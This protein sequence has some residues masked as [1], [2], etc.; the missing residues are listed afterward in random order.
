MDKRYKPLSLHD[1]ILLRERAIAEVLAHPE[2]SLAE[3][4]RHLRSGLR[5]TSAELAK[6]A[7]VGHR[8]LQDLEQGRSEGSVQT[9]NRILR[10]L[11]L[12]LGVVRVDQR[13]IDSDASQ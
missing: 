3:C 1:E 4:L 11:G 12:K 6:L 13:F 9:Y 8:T 7:G 10:L 5:M 2:W